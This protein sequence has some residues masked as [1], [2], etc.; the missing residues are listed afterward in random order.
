MEPTKPAPEEP[1][2]SEPIDYRKTATFRNEYAN[3]AFL[4]PS[5]WDLKINFGQLEQSI[6]PNVVVQHTGIS[7][8]W[9]QVKVFSYFL[10]LHVLAYE[11]ENGRIR[12]AKNIIRPVPI[13]DKKTAKNFSKAMERHKIIMQLYEDFM[14][15][16]PEAKPEE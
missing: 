15:A 7:M 9:N 10:R 16:N 12:M 8:P 3:N 6:G 14:A 11:Q 4:E 5:V 2:A 1:T 13:P